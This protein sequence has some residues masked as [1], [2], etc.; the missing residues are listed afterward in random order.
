MWKTINNKSIGFQLKLVISV[1]LIIAFSSVAAIVY[2]NSADIL[3]EETLQEQQSKLEAMAESIA[4]QFNIYLESA[5]EL[6]SAFRLGY[7]HGLKIENNTVNFAGQS[8][9]NVTLNGKSM[10]NDT[11][12]VDRFTQNTTAIA[13]LF[14]ASGNDFVR[15]ATSLKNNS[16]QRAL[17]S[18]LG[19]NHPG[20]NKLMNGQPYYA[21]VVLFG[22]DYLTYYSPIKDANGQVVA[23]S[24]IGL[25]IEEASKA[26]FSSVSNV[27][28]GDTGYTIVIDND[29]SNL[30][31]YLYH[32]EKK[33]K[34][35]S[36]L[37]VADYNGN[38]PFAQLFE[39]T[40]GLIKYPFE[41]NGVV[42]EKYLVYTEVPG[43]NW[44]LLGG[45][46]IQEVTKGSQ[47]LLTIIVIVALV[48]GIIT[49]IILGFY[50]NKMTTPLTTLAGY[51]DRLGQGEV[52]LSMEQGNI[53][54]GNEIE[55]LTGGVHNMAAKLNELVGSIR[56]TSESVQGQAT[57]V[58]DDA[59]HSLSQSDIQQE[60]VEQVVTAIEEM[61]SSAKSVAEQ[62]ESIAESV[63]S[64]N[65][66]SASGSELVSQ[67]SVEVAELNDQLRQSA[68]AIDRVS[69]ESD[70]IQSVTRMI[71]EI[72][73]QT[74]LLALNA[75]IEAARAGEQ[76]R[77]FAVVA[78]EV[79]TLAH[80]T[81]E[82][83]KEVVGIIEQL[84]GC[85]SSAVT[86]M[87]ESQKKGKL[88]TEQATQAGLALEGITTQVTSIAAQSEVIAATS[89]EQAQVSQEIATNATEISN[90]NRQGR[91][92][93]AQTS[94]S[95]N[96]LQ[97]LSKELQQQ[98]D[99]FH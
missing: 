21:K 64:A 47:Q 26:V 12:V 61:A 7:M 70:N 81:Q 62:V 53:H 59:Q 60:Q 13:T 80:R 72:A 28:W 68:D 15:V 66:D 23:I 99:Y 33:Q 4:G 46:F 77:G 50:L 41:Y 97:G 2:R 3:L 29:K 96:N 11:E 27:R 44:K 91:D 54:S 92:I 42:G 93:A 76:G 37:N 32:P 9:Q 83:V 8:V 48:A 6:E 38:K 94:Q 52:T 95:A 88:V 75:A 19:L 87:S 74:N 14:V 85:T 84:R 49:F 18:K 98:V 57:S 86:M 78:D 20:Y 31:V 65:E 82:S 58:S 17:G 16:G 24:F 89:E 79:R 63:R 43:W 5:K 71:D 30:G 34:G 45:T 10:I 36:I 51:M 35:E 40:S 90:L 1:L 39:S 25:S 56:N 73:E 55:R 22:H 67:V 69:H